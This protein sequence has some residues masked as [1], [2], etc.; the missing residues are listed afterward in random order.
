MV[1]KLTVGENTLRRLSGHSWFSSCTDRT[2]YSMGLS[3]ASNF[4]LRSM[5]G[6]INLVFV[7]G[8]WIDGHVLEGDFDETT[9]VPKHIEFVANCISL[10]GRSC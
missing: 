9:E 2:L 7:A 1:L 10:M 8:A 3:I 6:G 4:S 5:L